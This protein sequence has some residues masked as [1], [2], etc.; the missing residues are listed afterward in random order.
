MSAPSC[1]VERNRPMLPLRGVFELLLKHPQLLDMPLTHII[2]FL[3]YSLLA[4]PYIRSRCLP[5]SEAPTSLPSPVDELL[6]RCLNWEIDQVS[7]GWEVFREFVWGEK[8]ELRA[9][10]HQI[11]TYTT[12]AG[13]IL[14]SCKCE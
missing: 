5:G 3:Q 10:E 9:T 7:A 14:Q 13:D 12:L 6:A 4:T 1:L 8:L 2:A 11:H